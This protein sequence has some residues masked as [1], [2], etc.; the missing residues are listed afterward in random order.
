MRLLMAG[1]GFVVR[2]AGSVLGIIYLP[3]LMKGFIGARVQL[4]Q[5]AK[6][7]FSLLVVGN[8]EAASND[9]CRVCLSSNGFLMMM[10]PAGGGVRWPSGLL[11]GGSFSRW[12]CT[13]LSVLKRHCE[14]ARF[15][16]LDRVEE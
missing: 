7:S 13:T 2:D 4:V 14:V 16:G 10:S 15:V 12:F 5:G 11:G 9:G 1:V 8:F 6:G 3:D